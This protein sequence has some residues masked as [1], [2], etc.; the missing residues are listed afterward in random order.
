M[1]EEISRRLREAAEA[2]EPNRARILARVERGMAGPTV[3]HRDS[4]VARSWPR[5]G[6]RRVPVAAGTLATGGLAVAAI[7]QSPPARPDVP[8]TPVAPVRAVRPS[9]TPRPTPS[10]PRHRPPDHAG[11]L[12]PGAPPRRHR[13]REPGPAGSRSPGRAV[14]VGRLRWAEQQHL[15]GAEQPHPRSPPSRSPRSPWNCASPRPAACRTPASWRTL[16]ARRLHRHRAGERRCSWSTA[17]SSSRA[18]PY[19]PDS[20]SSPASTTTPPASASL[21]HDGYRVDAQSSRRLHRS[22]GRVHPAR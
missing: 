6:D 21:E 14:V 11:P 13:R 3:R 17:G 16:P 9:A 7:V 12:V 10:A 8:A 20:T 5:V 2:H 18:A 1:N 19:R 22:L 4:S 15:L